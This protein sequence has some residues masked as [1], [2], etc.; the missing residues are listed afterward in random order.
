MV[1]DGSRGHC[2]MIRRPPVMVSMVDRRVDGWLCCELC[3]KKVWFS[4]KNLVNKY[5]YPYL[6]CR[7]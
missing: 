7:A 2:P 1:L 5:K 6:I 4:Q 3:M